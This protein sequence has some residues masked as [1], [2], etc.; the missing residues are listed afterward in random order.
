MTFQR[1]TVTS[2]QNTIFPTPQ[3][4]SPALARDLEDCRKTSLNLLMAFLALQSITGSGGLTM[5]TLTLMLYTISLHIATSVGASHQL[6]AVI[7]GILHVI[8]A[9]G[10]FAVMSV[11]LAFAVKSPAMAILIVIFCFL[12]TMVA[13]F[14]C[15][16]MRCMKVI[17]D[18][19]P[20]AIPGDLPSEEPSI[21][22][23]ELTISA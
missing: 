17:M 15:L 8:P 11:E 18:Q 23:L 12:P 16:R 3:L 4:I 5:A 6:G 13:I 10:I 20:M 19:L 1:K 2:S 9:V 7:F 22:R 21:A 14:Q